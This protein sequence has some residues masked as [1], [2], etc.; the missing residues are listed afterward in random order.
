[1][2]HTLILAG[3]SGTRF[4]PLSRRMFPKQ[5]ISLD[6]AETLL[7]QTAARAKACAPYESMWVA[8]GEQLVAPIQL[9]L[10]ELDSSRVIVEPCGRNTAPCIGLAA[11]RMLAV[12]PDALMLVMP[13]DHDIGPIEAFQQAVERGAQLI[14]EDPHRL[15]LFGAK[16]T[17]PSTGFGYI[18]RGDELDERAP[19]SY[20]VAAFHEKPDEATAKRYLEQGTFYWNCGIFLWRA[21]RILAMLRQHQPGLFAHLERLQQVVGT[22]QWESTLA[23]EFPRMPSI[24]IDYAVLEK[25][26]NVLV[27]EAEFDWDD[28]GSWKALRRYFPVD[29]DNNVI[30]GKHQGSAKNCIIYSTSPTQLIATI[31][32]DDC[33]VVHHDD[34]IFV[35]QTDD[36][37]AL[38]DLLTEFTGQ[39]HLERYL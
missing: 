39:D 29:S 21:D 19:S 11:L 7:Q 1:M 30:V 28:L 25:A 8:T 15:V 2:L 34:V 16:P 24:S 9:Q 12:D 5:L 33:V 38:K 13:S 17:F 10:P 36:E 4:W 18:E 23:H 31:G 6:G 37:Q 35:A 22:D 3:G 27:I 20:H 14:D 26:N 32:L